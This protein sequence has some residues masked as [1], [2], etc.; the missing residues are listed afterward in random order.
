[1]ATLM[2]LRGPTTKG[3][4]WRSAAS[5]SIPWL[6]NSRSTCLIACLV[7][8]P[9]ARAS[10]WPMVCTAREAVLRTPRVALAKDSTRLACRSPSNRPARK[11]CTSVKQSVWAGVISRL[12]IVG[13]G[14]EI[15][16]RLAQGNAMLAHN[17]LPITAR[18]PQIWLEPPQPDTGLLRCFRRSENEGSPEEPT[19]KF[20]DEPMFHADLHSR[21]HS[22]GGDP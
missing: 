20:A 2:P 11:R 9:R 6:D 4:Q 19:I 8:R 5:R 18:Q 1:M 16:D 13:A 17:R 12:R 21:R 14:G 3:T 15:A 7:R 10:P 22:P